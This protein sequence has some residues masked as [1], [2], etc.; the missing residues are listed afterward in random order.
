MLEIPFTHFRKDCLKVAQETAK[1]AIERS[2]TTCFICGQQLALDSSKRRNHIG[3]HILK[4]M[5]H[6]PEAMTHVNLVREP[7][8]LSRYCALILLITGWA[9]SMRHLWQIN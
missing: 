2:K 6:V 8:V 3:M 9:A 4:M 1:A 5:R 7:P